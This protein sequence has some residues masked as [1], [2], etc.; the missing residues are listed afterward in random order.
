MSDSN[1]STSIDAIA[2]VCLPAFWKQSPEIW[3]IHAESVFVNSHVT[4]NA[5][6]VDFVIGALDEES[7]RTVIDLLGSTVSNDTI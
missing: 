1:D 5:A 7:I 3:F 4:A 6:R 2:N